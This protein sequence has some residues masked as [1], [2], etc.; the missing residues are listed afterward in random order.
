MTVT[1]GVVGDAGES[2]ILVTDIDVSSQACR[3]TPGDIGHG[4]S[5]FSGQRVVIFIFFSVE[6]KDIHHL[7]GGSCPRPGGEG[8][9]RVLLRLKV[10]QRALLFLD[11]IQGATREAEESIGDMGIA[12]GGLNGGMSEQGLNHPDVVT[13]FQKVGGKGVP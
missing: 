11:Q 6:A 9:H 8:F 3:S 13:T 7:Q 2:A 5:L 12:L 10:G 4:F 1:A